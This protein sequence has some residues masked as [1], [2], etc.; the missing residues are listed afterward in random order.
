MFGKSYEM[1]QLEDRVKALEELAGAKKDA[2]ALTAIE[3]IR[4]N[5]QMPSNHMELVDYGFFT[6]Q[7]PK[8]VALSKVMEQ[9]LAHLGLQVTYTPE[10]KEPEQVGLS[11]VGKKR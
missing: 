2:T 10:H 8:R 9:V 1:K 6:A 11:K 3:E 5:T 7:I 4:M